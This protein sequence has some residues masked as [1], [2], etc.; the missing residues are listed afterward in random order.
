MRIFLS[1]LIVVTSFS[2]TLLPTKAPAESECFIQA[3]NGQHQDLSR[4]CGGGSGNRTSTNTNG[5]YRIPIIRRLNGIPTVEVVFNGK[6]RYEMLFD[7][8]ASGVVITESM[9]KL[10]GV[11]K[12]EGGLASTAGGVIPY[13]LG[14]VNSLQAG[15]LMQQNITVGIISQ[16]DDLGLLGQDFFGH[17]DITIKKDVIELHPRR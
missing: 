17:Y 15:N 13:H 3:P 14:R 8:G 4:I 11:R 7:T 10:M 2:L 12:Q 1:A 16:T 6:H 9:A 5:V